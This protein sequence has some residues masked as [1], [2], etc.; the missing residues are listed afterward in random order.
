[1]GSITGCRRR[2]KNWPLPSDP[3]A[4][5]QPCH[6]IGQRHRAR[7]HPRAPEGTP[8]AAADGHIRPTTCNIL[9]LLAASWRNG[10]AALVILR[11]ETPIDRAAILAVHAAAFAHPEK[12]VSPEARLV[13]ELRHDGDIVSGL[14]IV[15]EANSVVV[16]H[17]VCSRARIEDSASLGLGPLGVLPAHQRRGV[18]H[19]LMH[20]V[21]AAAD[22]LDEPAVVLLGDPGYYRRFGFMLGPNP[23][24]AT[25]PS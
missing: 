13:D 3:P 24:C 20:A 12:I 22:A 9:S 23:G 18:G 8:G 2:S 15:A 19:P 1:M 6:P 5:V 14:S 16:G 25:C 10:K 17:V 21:L 7:T 11:R 4:P